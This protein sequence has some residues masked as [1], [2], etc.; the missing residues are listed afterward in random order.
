M[1]PSLKVGQYKA[2]IKQA[3]MFGPGKF[4]NASLI[5]GIELRLL[6]SK[7]GITRC[8]TKALASLVNIRLAI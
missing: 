3:R 1:V 6:L 2:A 8:S 7:W 4:F 5:F